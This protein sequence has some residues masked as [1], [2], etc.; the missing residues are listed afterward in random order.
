MRL[1]DG[2]TPFSS[3]VR[4]GIPCSAEKMEH[5]WWTVTH[6]RLSQMR[7]YMITGGKGTLLSLIYTMSQKTAPFY[8]CSNSAKSFYTE[9]IIGIHIPS[10]IWNKMTS[11]SSISFEGCLYTGLWNGENVHVLWQMSV[12][13]HKL[14]VC[15]TYCQMFQLST[16]GPK[17]LMSLMSTICPQPKTSLIN[18]L[19]MTVCWMLDRSSFRRRLNSS[20]SRTKF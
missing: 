2:R 6:G 8:F 19:T 15:K 13:S 16:T 18:H 17:R 1:T 10:Q 12:L 20:T 14:K 4:A 5:Y 7:Y 11:K 3:L 9:V